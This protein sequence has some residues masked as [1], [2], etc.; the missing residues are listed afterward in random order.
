MTR[1][2]LAAALLAGGCIRNNTP[3][4]DAKTLAEIDAEIAERQAAIQDLGAKISMSAEGLERSGSFSGDMTWLPPDSFRLDAFKQV[5]PH[6]FT[7]ITVGDRFLLHIIP[8]GKAVVGNLKGQERR[9][10]ELTAAFAWLAERPEPGDSREIEEE[11]ADHFIVATRRGGTVVRRQRVERPSLFVT[12]VALYGADGKETSRVA[13][14]DYRAVKP[15]AA[16]PGPEA[17]IPWRVVVRGR[18][19]EGRDYVLETKMRI[20]YLNEGVEPGLFDL[21]PPEGIGVEEAK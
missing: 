19:D 7:F 6:F 4:S 14:S 13:I 18:T 1:L 3:E 12:E 9:H 11:A 21:T 10:P 17:W 16:K 8:D 15:P 20:V 5:G 2:A